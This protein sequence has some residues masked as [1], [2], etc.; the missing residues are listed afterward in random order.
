MVP[1]QACPAHHQRADVNKELPILQV[2]G[3]HASQTD[4]GRV[5]HQTQQQPHQTMSDTIPS[6]MQSCEQIMTAALHPSLAL[7][8][9]DPEEEVFALD[10]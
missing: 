10:I 2:A 5:Y 7:L 1:M 3:R 6:E 9:D 8:H 4:T